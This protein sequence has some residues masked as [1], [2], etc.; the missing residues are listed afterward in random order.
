MLRIMITL[1]AL[2]LPLLPIAPQLPLKFSQAKAQSPEKLKANEE[3][4]RQQMLAMSRQL[5]VTCTTCH[6][7]ENF[8]ADDL[9][10]FK[11]ARAHIKLT[12]LL[13]D[14][15]FDGSKKGQPKADCY[16]CHRG[17]LIPDYRELLDPLRKEPTKKKVEQK[18]ELLSEPSTVIDPLEKD[19]LEKKK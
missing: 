1:C 17:K 8:V 2:L 9:P 18:E 5:G 14:G 12:Q 6:K 7:T 10:A 11:T 13:I 3:E 4:V 16:L 15:G 19:K